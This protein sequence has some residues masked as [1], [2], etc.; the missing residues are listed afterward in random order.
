VYREAGG[1]WYWYYNVSTACMGVGSSSTAS[2]YA[3]YAANSIYSAGNVVAAS[4]ERK[5]ENIEPIKD[6]L[7]IVK[8]LVGVYYNMI[9]D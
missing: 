1:G 3:I 6:A 2:G 7:S 9:E 8:N 5:K 4:D